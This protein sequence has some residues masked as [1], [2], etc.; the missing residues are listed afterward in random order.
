MSSLDLNIKPEGENSY[1]F[2]IVNRLFLKSDENIPANAI[3]YSPGSVLTAFLPFLILVNKS[4]HEMTE[5][6]RGT[7]V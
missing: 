5:K 2:S 7:Y 4:E 3:A 1:I 6:K